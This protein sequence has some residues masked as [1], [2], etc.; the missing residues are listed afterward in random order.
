[1]AVPS[2]RSGAVGIGNSTIT[3]ERRKTTASIRDHGENFK[4]PSLDDKL[5]FN[6]NIH[7]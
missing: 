6:Y 2:V 3:W 5:I 1:M 4:S 7:V